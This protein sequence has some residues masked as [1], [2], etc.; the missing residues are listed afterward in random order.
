MT[1]AKLVP[2]KGARKNGAITA[3]V[4]AFNNAT[5]RDACYENGELQKE[6]LAAWKHRFRH[7]QIYSKMQKEYRQAA[8]LHDVLRVWKAAKDYPSVPVVATGP[9]S[10]LANNADDI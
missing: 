4:R 9:L 7:P 10:N 2:I 5:Q 8:E 3:F 1:D 6:L